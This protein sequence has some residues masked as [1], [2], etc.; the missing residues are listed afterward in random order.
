MSHN[1]TCDRCER[2][3]GTTKVVVYR[4]RNGEVV[5]GTVLC[6]R[7]AYAGLAELDLKVPVEAEG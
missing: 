5:D 2:E 3:K 6:S 4:L 1:G 7:C